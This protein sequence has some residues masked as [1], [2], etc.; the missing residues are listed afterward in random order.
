MKA[1]TAQNPHVSPY[2]IK[3]KV[4]GVQGSKLIQEY[5]K[6]LCINNEGKDSFFSYMKQ[7]FKTCFT[8]YSES[9]LKLDSIENIDKPAVLRC[10]SDS[11]YSNSNTRNNENIHLNKVL[12][13]QSEISPLY[14]PSLYVGNTL[15]N[16]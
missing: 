15:Y 1:S 6:Q 7:L 14:H 2:P 3:K 16:V 9:C 10:M 13:I 8:D 5:V 12:N 4:N 11:W